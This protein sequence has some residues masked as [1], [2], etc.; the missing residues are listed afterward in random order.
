MHPRFGTNHL[1]NPV[2]T[3]VQRTLIR[4]GVIAAILSLLIGLTGGW[5]LGR[6]R[7][8]AAQR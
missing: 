7:V 4:D 5:W 8:A 1:D 3:K 2:L 6:K